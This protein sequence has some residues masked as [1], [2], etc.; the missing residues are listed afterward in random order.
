VHSFTATPALCRL[1]G[2]DI[3]WHTSLAVMWRQWRSAYCKP[4]GLQA[5]MMLLLICSQ[6]RLHYI[7]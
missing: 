1:K 2:G 4:T 3:E 6:W 5:V 7:H